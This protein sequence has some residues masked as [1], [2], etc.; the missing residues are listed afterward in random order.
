MS[1]PGAQQ[2]RNFEV[3]LPWDKR[4]EARE[5]A[6]FDVIMRLEETLKALDGRMVL[7]PDSTFR[8]WL[9]K[10]GK[11]TETAEPKKEDFQRWLKAAETELA[12]Q[13]KGQMGVFSRGEWWTEGHGDFQEAIRALHALQLQ[14][15]CA[16]LRKSKA[17]FTPHLPGDRLV[18]GAMA[19]AVGVLQAHMDGDFETR[20]KASWTLQDDSPEAKGWLSEQGVEDAVYTVLNPIVATAAV[21]YPAIP[22][23]KKAHKKAFAKYIKLYLRDQADVPTKIRCTFHWTDPPLESLPTQPPPVPV[24]KVIDLPGYLATQKENFPDLHL[25]GAGSM[26]L[27]RRVREAHYLQKK[28]DRTTFRTG[29]IYLVFLGVADAIVSG[30]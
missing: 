27:Y 8:K 4:R 7:P 18:K 26:A 3:R 1:L 16:E 5:K 19:K 14:Q 20:L 29:L 12:A 30:L 6:E 2:A 25:V 13:S 28:E 23:V 22:A 21:I 10:H 11:D 15:L 24:P 17:V 9:E